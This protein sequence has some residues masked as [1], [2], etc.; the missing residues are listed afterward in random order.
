MSDKKIEVGELAQELVNQMHQ[1]G[2][3]LAMTYGEQGESF[4]NTSDK[5]Q[6]L[7]MW[8]LSDKADKIAAQAEA[9]NSILIGVGLEVR[10]G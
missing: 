6:D 9:L 2:A 8:G 10:H 3:M 5:L 1:L 7:F 4:R